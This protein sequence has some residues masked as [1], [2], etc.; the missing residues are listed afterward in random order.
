MVGEWRG[1]GRGAGGFGGGF[2]G[3]GV[4]LVESVVIAVVWDLGEG[5]GV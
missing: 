4:D 1:D 2:G 5:V 3:L